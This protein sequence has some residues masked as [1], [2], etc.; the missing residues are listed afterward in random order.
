MVSTTS[1]P[2]Q[3]SVTVPGKSVK[4]DTAT[5]M[6]I[7][8]TVSGHLRNEP[9]DGLSVSGSPVLSVILPFK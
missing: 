1:F 8:D 7:P 4:N 5:Y 3:L 9:S 6:E 2:I